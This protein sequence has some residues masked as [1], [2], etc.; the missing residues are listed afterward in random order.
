MKYRAT[1]LRRIFGA[2]SAQIQDEN[3]TWD[4]MG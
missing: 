3:Q 2:S 4:E 1:H